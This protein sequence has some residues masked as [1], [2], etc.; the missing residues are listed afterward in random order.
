MAWGQRCVKGLAGMTLALAGALAHAGPYSAMYVFGDSLS[1]VGNA[2]AFTSGLWPSS[3]YYTDGTVSGRFTNGTNFVDGLSGYLGLSVTPS[4]AAGTDYAY[5]GARVGSSVVPAFTA[6]INTF[7]TGLPGTGADPNALYVVWIGANDM[8]DAIEAAAA[9]N[10]LAPVASGVGSAMAGIATGI[11]ALAASGAQHFLVMN[12]PDLS[13]TP[14]IRGLGSTQLSTLAQG[15]SMGFN[16]ALA[17]LVGT[18]LGA[19]DITLF[20]VFGAQTEVANNPAAYGFTNTTDACYS[21]DVDGSG[22]PPGSPVSV[23]ADAS[24]YMY[25]DYIHPS[26]ALHSRMALLAYDA[27]AVPEPASLSL[28]LSSLGMMAY[29]RRRPMR[30]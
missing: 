10:S 22:R 8:F 3:T 2:A 5:G 13:L 16:G 11:G 25:F 23:C 12:L 26:S 19:L 7:V 29:L 27:L 17:N 28:L 4:L 15:A 30:G 1:D 18:T 24:G 20:D 14:A 21:G 9:A 6:Q